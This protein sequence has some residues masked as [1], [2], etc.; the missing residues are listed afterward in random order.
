MGTASTDPTAET[1]PRAPAE[2]LPR[3]TL[4]V[5]GLGKITRA[6]VRP[7]PL[8]LF[9]GENNT[10]KSY[11]AT[12]LWGLHRYI[13][14]LIDSDRPDNSATERLCS[15]WVHNF[16]KSP[17]SAKLTPNDA[18]LFFTRLNEVLQR[19]ASHL[20]TQ[21]FN[22]EGLQMNRMALEDLEAIPIEAHYEESNEAGA[23]WTSRLEF[24]PDQVFVRRNIGA[25]NEAATAAFRATTEDFGKVLTR[26][27][28]LSDHNDALYLPASRTGFMLLYP[29]VIRTDIERR[30]IRGRSRREVPAELTAPMIEFL[31]FIAAGPRPGTRSRHSDLADELEAHL[32]GTLEIGS[33]L[34][35]RRYAFRPE[36]GS[37]L[38]MALAS[39][40]VT[41]LAPIIAVLRHTDPGFLVVEEP[42]AHL[43]PELQCVMARLL[44]RLVRR[45]VQVCVTTHSEN[46][47]Q[48]INNL[49]KV[50]LLRDRGAD[51][52]AFK[53]GDDEYLRADE[54]AAYEFRREAAG[55]EVVALE[56]T[57]EGIAMPLFNRALTELTGQTVDLQ[58]AIDATAPG[59]PRA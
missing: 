22:R 16:L 28:V 17:G 23:A 13:D 24:D 11:L 4:V 21:A 34:G 14:D 58:Q 39:S 1:P 51:V 37:A 3:W 54:V 48:Q 15:E 8:T 59:E 18:A 44:V 53:L 31:E 36:G 42:E 56:T 5:E 26:M 55:T 45:G 19:R 7:A 57:P 38:P 43:H 33:D 12:L 49:L 25:S 29:D 30:K 10:G 20:L 52:S 47:C 40:L 50:G 41:E 32:H 46:F 9:V 6:R 35:A 27:L 2:R